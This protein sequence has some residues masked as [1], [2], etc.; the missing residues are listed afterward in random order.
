LEVTKETGYGNGIK[1]PRVMLK[2]NKKELQ[3]FRCYEDGFSKFLH[4][5][6]IHMV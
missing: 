5:G 2:K 4:V 6:D 3:N 1:F